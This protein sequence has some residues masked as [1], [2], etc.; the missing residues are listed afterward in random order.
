MTSK[1]KVIVN[2]GYWKGD[3][4]DLAIVWL[5]KWQLTSL[6][7]KV[8]DEKQDGLARQ[9]QVHSMSNNA[10]GDKE[11]FFSGMAWYYGDNDFY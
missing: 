8:S 6:E 2:N 3:A 7:G 5:L 11:Y 4:T 1:G 10:N 9:L